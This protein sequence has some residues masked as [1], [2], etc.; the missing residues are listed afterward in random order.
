M[1]HSHR[2]V[3]DTVVDRAIDKCF[4]TGHERLATLKTETLLVRILARDELF[5]RLGPHE[6]VENHPLLFDGVIPGFGDLDAFTNP[7]TLVL[8]RDVDILDP[9]SPT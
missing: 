3:L 9:N 8:V 6:S 2:D 7:V 1:W 4:H 5:E